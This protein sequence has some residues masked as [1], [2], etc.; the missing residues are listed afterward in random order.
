MKVSDKDFDQLFNSKL[1]DMEVEPSAKVWGNIADELDG[2]QK[3]KIPLMRVAAGIIVIMAIG[4][5]FLRP[6]TQKIQLHASATK[7]PT[8]MSQSSPMV[9]PIQPQDIS[10][11]TTAIAEA[12]PQV[13]RRSNKAMVEQVK[14]AVNDQVDTGQNATPY[15]ADANTNPV[16]NVN[17]QLNTP[18]DRSGTSTMPDT[19]TNIIAK[20]T[21]VEPVKN[22]NAN[23]V[24][25]V[26]TD[27]QKPAEPAK[28]KRIRSL[29][30]LLNVVIAK[31]DKRE[32]KV[33]EFTNSND[34][35][36][37]NVTGLNLGIVRAKKQN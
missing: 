10:G 20:N 27:T 5:F 1:A 13:K 17:T 2:K 34:D 23:R 11:T 3:G 4:V 6:E 21:N 36:T 32:D 25:A 30:D 29:G 28:K 16:D 33:I 37:F 7:T 15:I 14:S 24:I 31:V 22:I 12:K 35:D 18:A 26:N 8:D 9:T 19:K